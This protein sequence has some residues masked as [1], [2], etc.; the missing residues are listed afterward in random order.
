MNADDVG[1]GEESVERHEGHP[2]LARPR[3]LDVRVVGQQAHP[4]SRQALRDKDADSAQPENARGLV[5]QLHPRPLRALPLAATQRRV[6]RGDPA[7]DRQQQADRVLSGT[8]DVRLGSVDDHHPAAGRRRDVD[9]VQ[10]H[11]GAGDNAQVRRRRQ[12]LRVNLGGASDDHGVD[13]RQR[14]NERRTVGPVDGAHLEVVREQ[15]EPGLRQLLGDQHDR[16]WH[17]CTLR[18]ACPARSA[19]AAGGASV[20]AR[21]LTR[22]LVAAAGRDRASSGPA[23]CGP[24]QRRSGS[25]A[26]SWCAR[27]RRGRRPGRAPRRPARRPRNRRGTRGR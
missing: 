3:S 23:N 27:S 17:Q 8:D 26:R 14:G 6:R 10:A 13:V 18:L 12:R 1:F 5:E 15:V 4:E 21:R 16:T 2:Q 19:A 20:L 22:G 9:V 11:P 25:R 7:G 24:G